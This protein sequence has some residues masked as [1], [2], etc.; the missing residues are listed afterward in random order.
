MYTTRMPSEIHMQFV[1]NA[2]DKKYKRIANL[3]YSFYQYC[4]ISF[5]VTLSID[6]ATEHWFSLRPFII[7]KMFCFAVELRVSLS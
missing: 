6:V 3:N 1:D 5:F 4:F 2:S 7:F